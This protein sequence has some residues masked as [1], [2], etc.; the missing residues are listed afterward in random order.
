M[1]SV[2]TLGAMPLRDLASFVVFRFAALK[3]SEYRATFI[4]DLVTAHY[5]FSAAANEKAIIVLTEGLEYALREG[6]LGLDQRSTAGAGL[7]PLRLTRAGEQFIATNGRAA[8]WRDLAVRE[9]LHPV[10]AADALIELERGVKHHPD[11]IFKAFKAVVCTAYNLKH[12]H[13]LVAAGN[14]V[15][16]A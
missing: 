7:H 5:A 14:W 9:L 8:S 3:K 4:G 2:D 13:A 6:L 11:A 1:P 10:I 16:T 15:L 12:L